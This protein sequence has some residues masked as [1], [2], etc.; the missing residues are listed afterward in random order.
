MQDHELHGYIRSYSRR[1][2]ED[3]EAINKRVKE[4]PGTAGDQGEIS[5]QKLLEDWLPEGY[6]VVTKGRILGANGLASPQ[7]DLIVLKP[8]YPK[9]LKTEKYYL[10]NGVAAA[11]ECK[12]NIK[13]SHFDKIFQTSKKIAELETNK[14]NKA[15]SEIIS[16]IIYGVLAH[17][18]DLRGN[19]DEKIKKIDEKLVQVAKSTSTHPRD[20]PE[21]LCIADLA[22]W[23]VAHCLKSKLLFQEKT[24]EERRLKADYFKKISSHPCILDIDRGNYRELVFERPHSSFI[25]LY[26]PPLNNKGEENNYAKFYTPLGS[27]IASFY[28]KMSYRD[29]NLLEIVEYFKSVHIPYSS[30]GVSSF[31]TDLV[32]SREIISEENWAK[33]KN[34]FRESDLKEIYF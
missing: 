6:T 14:Y 27:F 2:A 7:I 8:N 1:I 26:A 30:G 20:L 13:L 16:P 33:L 5:W 19:I 31:T 10:F 11:F 22:S 15:S 9:F 3:Y 12:I 32:W 4:D 17:T 18:S 34:N 25:T 23:R 24:E 29:K 28:D 21:L